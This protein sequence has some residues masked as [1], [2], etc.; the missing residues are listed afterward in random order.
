MHFFWFSRLFCQN[1]SPRRNRIPASVSHSHWV[2]CSAVTVSQYR[3]ERYLSYCCQVFQLKS[4]GIQYSLHLSIHIIRFSTVQK[5][6]NSEAIH[7]LYKRYT[8]RLSAAG[9]VQL[10][11]QKYKSAIQHSIGISPRLLGLFPQQKDAGGFFCLNYKAV[12]KLSIFSGGVFP[13]PPWHIN[14]NIYC[15]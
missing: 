3:I 7:A 11:E 13:E 1:C 8:E 6:I 4:P 12:T 5:N 2:I 10:F 15:Q 14:G 9:H